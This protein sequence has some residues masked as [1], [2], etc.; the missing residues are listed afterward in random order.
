MY[1]PRKSLRVIGQGWVETICSGISHSER[2]WAVDGKGDTAC[3]ANIESIG[4][5]PD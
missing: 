3:A 5:I 4:W 2:E 1:M